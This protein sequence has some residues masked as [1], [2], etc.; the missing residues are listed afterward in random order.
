[1]KAM[2]PVRSSRPCVAPKLGL[3]E[4][5]KIRTRKAI[6]QAAYRLFAAQGYDATPVD[7]IAEAAEVSPST[8]FRYYPTKEDILFTD[9]Y[10][11]VIAE[12]LAKRPPEEP[13]VTALREALCSVLSLQVDDD[14]ASEAMQ[15]ML[16]I[17]DV[18]SVRARMAEHTA[19]TSRLLTQVLSERTGRPEDDLELR[20][21]TGAVMSALTE[22]M[23]HWIENGLDGELTTP[24][25]HALR[26]LERG[27]TL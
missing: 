10:D 2:T 18:P 13:P 3:R 20:I 1:M 14:E 4:R 7:Q 23:Y 27:L 11:P 15:R 22:A 16:L 6:R 24:V 9:E 26:V 17:R 5:K 8:V 21:V 19:A 12:A 25:A